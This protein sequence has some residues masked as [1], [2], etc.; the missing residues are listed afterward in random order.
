MKLDNS[1]LQE[2]FPEIAKE[3]HN[4]KNGDLTPLN[5]SYGSEKMVWWICAACGTEYQSRINNRTS[6]IS[7]NSVSCPHCKSIKKSTS[8]SK[9]VLNIDTGQIFESVKA[10]N[11]YYGKKQTN[12]SAVCRGERSLALG[13]HWKYLDE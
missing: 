9:P 11:E 2:R 1:S 4:T 10:A 8:K 3:W 5:V 6:F 13:Y 7:R 12:I